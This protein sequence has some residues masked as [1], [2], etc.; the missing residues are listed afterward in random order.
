MR[1]GTRAS[2]L[3]RLQTQIVVDKLLARSP[4]QTIEVVPV[5]TGGDKIVDRPI[6]ELGF[7]G[8]F[9]KELE[10]ALLRKE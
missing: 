2:K 8:V 6:A 7:S 1:A 5:T 10:D 9:V 4:G 3:A